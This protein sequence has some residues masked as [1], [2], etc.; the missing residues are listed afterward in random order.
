MIVLSPAAGLASLPII[1]Q[2]P[3]AALRIPDILAVRS[4]GFLPEVI[5]ETHWLYWVAGAAVALILLHLGRSRADKNLFRIGLILAAGTVLWVAAA[6]LLDTPG[7]RLRDAHN[8]LAE[9][10]TKNDVDKILTYL[11]P[12]FR[13]TALGITVS[14]DAK[15]NLAAILKS[16]GIRKNHITAYTSERSGN[17]ATTHLTVITESSNGAV[18]TS[19][20]L[21]WEDLPDSD[22]KINTADLLKINDQ[23]AG[24]IQIPRNLF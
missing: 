20:Q 1:G 3:L 11:A 6:L 18:K 23:D 10:A 4:P 22:W 21:F 5:F 14:A 12:N 17:A 2:T 13:S 19:W 24:T 9:A 15:D 16:A 8:A 7:E